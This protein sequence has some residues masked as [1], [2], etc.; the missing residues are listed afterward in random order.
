MIVNVG[1]GT[2]TAVASIQS[3]SIIARVSKI[4][5]AGISK[6]L[7]ILTKNPVT[8]LFHESRYQPLNVNSGTTTTSQILTA[9]TGNVAMLYFIVRPQTGLSGD[10]AFSFTE[11]KDWNLLDAIGTSL[12]GGSNLNSRLSVLQLGKYWSQS[13]YLAEAYKGTSN[14]FVYIWSFSPDINVSSMTGQQLGSRLF[15]GSETLNINFTSSLSSA[16]CIDVFTMNY[17]GAIQ[18][19]TTVNKIMTF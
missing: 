18:T 3:T 12:V 1:G 17:A 16:V 7:A 6:S 5:D 2:G 15:R 10:S 9:I 4:D 14:A 11:I 19:L 13:S 8:S